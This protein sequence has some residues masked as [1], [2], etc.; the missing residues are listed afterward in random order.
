MN[1]FMLSVGN[2]LKVFTLLDK[3]FEMYLGSYMQ[4]L[5]GIN[6]MY[7]YSYRYR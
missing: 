2:S 5:E 7:P 3:R 6:L 1:K 4:A